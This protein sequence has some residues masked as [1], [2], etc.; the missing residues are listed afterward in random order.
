MVWNM[1]SAQSSNWLREAGGA[2]AMVPVT[3]NGRSVMLD[4][5]EVTFEDLI[6]LA[7]PGVDLSNPESRALTVTYRRGPP[8]RPE[9]SLISRERIEVR[10]GEVFNVTATTKS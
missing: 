5:P 6:G 1:S 7:F 8:A 4:R 10:H 9:G 3:V 2:R